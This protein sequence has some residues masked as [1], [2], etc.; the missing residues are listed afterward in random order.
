MSAGGTVPGPAADRLDLNVLDRAFARAAEQAADGTAPFVILAVAN[1]AGT[2]RAEAHGG[3]GLA[4][5]GLDAICLLASVTKPLTA[6]GIVRLVA[7][8]RLALTDPV[9]RYLPG[10]GAPGKPTV[11]IWHLL[12]HTSG[13]PD[14][15]LEGLLTGRIS[16][17][18]LVRRAA[19]APLRFSPGT[20]YEYVSSTFSL[21]G[22]IV[23]EVTGDPFEAFLTS[24]IL[25]PLGMPDTAFDA[26][27]RAPGRVAPLAGATA[28]GS[29]RP[30][31]PLGLSDGDRAA[32]AALALPGAGLFATAGD[33]VRFGRA[34]LRGGELDGSRI[35][36]S[37]YVELMTREQTTGGVGATADSTLADHYALGW[38]KPSPSTSP[39]S[40]AAFGHGG[41]TGTRLWID[42]AHDLVIVYLTGVWGFPT[43]EIDVVVQAVYAALR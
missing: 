28:P 38:G 10:F 6:S 20:R 11:T 9:E 16:R 23:E 39:A 36:P 2:V 17:A 21:L 14:F 5:V 13:V 31:A 37:P 43:R 42:P 4:G 1:G 7:D 3:P 25:D 32:F 22:A 8:G 41:A 27:D 35:L 40:A 19:S 33:L 12:T 34:M 18:E 30:W 29:R 24:E 15:E 26:W